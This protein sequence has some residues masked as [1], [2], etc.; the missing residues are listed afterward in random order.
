MGISDCEL[1]IFKKVLVGSGGMTSVHKLPARDQLCEEIA[2]LLRPA[3]LMLPNC[4][5]R[6]WPM[7]EDLA[8]LLKALSTRPVSQQRGR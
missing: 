6:P 3:R 4:L 7:P 2:E 5:P 8:C 1:R